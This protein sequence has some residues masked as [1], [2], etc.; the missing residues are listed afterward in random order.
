M[1]A[2]LGAFH[3]KGVRQVAGAGQPFFADDGGGAGRRHNGHQLGA[4]FFL[5][6]VAEI[7]QNFGQFRGKARAGK[8]DVRALH[9]GG[10]HQG[11]EVG[12]GDHDVDADDAVGDLARFFDFRGQGAAVGANRVLGHIRFAHADHCAG[13]NADA[14]L[15]GHSGGEAMQGNADAHA[16]LDD[17]SFGDK[18][19][20]FK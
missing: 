14:A 3:H 4:E 15:G 19:A 16:A 13:D 7:A 17:G 5:F 9:N 1:A 18:V 11:G 2:G 12:Q 8:D 10:A 20:D 6:L